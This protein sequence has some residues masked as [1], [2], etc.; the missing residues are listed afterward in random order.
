MNYDHCTSLDA[1]LADDLSAEEGARFGAHLQQCDACRDAVDQQQWIDS[2][3]TSPLVGELESPPPALL[4]CGRVTLQPS[5]RLAHVVACIF[6]AAAAVAVAAG[7]TALQ[8]WHKVGT[9]LPVDVVVHD[10]DRSSV[11]GFNDDDVEAES[12]PVATFV[13]GPEVLVV[14]IA[15]RHADVTIVRVYPTYQPSIDD[16]ANI[17]R[18]D[19]EQLNGG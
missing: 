10:E 2:L 11:A 7:W 9:P 5:R 6:A 3:L 15:S 16:Q 13:G 18:F 1:Y 12:Q 8:P 17:E 14:P 19:L 4:D